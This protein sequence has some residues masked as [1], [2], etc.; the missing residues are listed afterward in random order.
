MI[1]RPSPQPLSSSASNVPLS[2]VINTTACS[3]AAIVLLLRLLS[4]DRLFLHRPSLFLSSLPSLS[5]IPAISLP[6][7]IARTKLHPLAGLGHCLL[8]SLPVASSP[9]PPAASSYDSSLWPAATTKPSFDA[10]TPATGQPL[11][12][13]SM[14]AKA[15][16]NATA[17]L[18][19][20]SSAFSS[21]C[22]SPCWTSL[23]PSSIPG[24]FYRSQALLCRSLDLLFFIIAE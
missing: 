15:L 22:H 21:L 3:H 8:S 13:S 24:H 12:S 11:S 10:P 19:S 4:L 17:I 9:G 14:A 5:A 16:T 2:W 6:S 1:A 20:A 18:L 23:P 7:L